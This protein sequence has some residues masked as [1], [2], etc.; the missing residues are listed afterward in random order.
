[1]PQKVAK[2][3][4][5]TAIQQRRLDTLEV[6]TKVLNCIF[7]MPAMSMCVFQEGGP[8]G[9]CCV[10]GGKLGSLY[11]TKFSSDPSYLREVKLQWKEEDGALHMFNTFAHDYDLLNHPMPAIAKIDTL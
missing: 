10:K 4:T 8:C 7:W 6:S 5:K 9:S 3:M 11:S 1:M 2:L